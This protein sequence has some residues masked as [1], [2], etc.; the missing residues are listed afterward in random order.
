MESIKRLLRRPGRDDF[1]QMVMDAIRRAGYTDSIQ[2][3]RQSF[4]L[5][6]AGGNHAYLANAYSD[7]LKAPNRQRAQIVTRYAAAWVTVRQRSLAREPVLVEGVLPNLLPVVRTRSFHDTLRL[8]ARAERLG[9]Q[10][11][12]L[13]P[14]ADHLAV[15]LAI[16]WPTTSSYVDREKL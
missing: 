13:V 4:K 10:D 3:D 9:E 1:A 2:Y 16:D 5:V 15:S 14:L 6:M 11:V 8:Q 12:P 7:C